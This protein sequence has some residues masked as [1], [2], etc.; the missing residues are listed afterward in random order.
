M[1]NEFWQYNNIPVIKF[2]KLKL[3]YVLRIV[4]I[5]YTYSYNLSSLICNSF[6]W[7]FYQSVLKIQ[8]IYDIYSFILWVIDSFILY[9]KYILLQISSGLLVL[10]L[11]NLKTLFVIELNKKIFITPKSCKW[12][13]LC[14]VYIK[15]YSEKVIDLI[16]ENNKNI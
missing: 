3:Y 14:N 10:C 7:K 1:Q 4:E 9:I 6:N 5:K 16:Q 8:V 2:S 11:F 15:F 12:L 13:C